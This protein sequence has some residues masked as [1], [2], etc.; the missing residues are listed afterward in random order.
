MI[1]YENLAKGRWFT[2]FL[3]V[4]LGNIG[5]EY[6][7]MGSWRQKGDKKKSDEAAARFFELLDLTLAD[8]RWAGARRRELSRLREEIAGEVLDQNKPGNLQKY[9]DY[10]VLASK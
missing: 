1:F 6:S 10:F 3:A 5:S 2:F 9:F 7:R 8:R 4:Q